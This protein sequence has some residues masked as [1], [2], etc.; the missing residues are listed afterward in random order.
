M[1]IVGGRV[2]GIETLE[3]RS[4]TAFG[5]TG[6]SGNRNYCD[7]PVQNYVVESPR[8]YAVYDLRY[9]L[10]RLLKPLYYGINLLDGCRTVVRSKHSNALVM[11]HRSKLFILTTGGGTFNRD[12]INRIDNCR[13][14]N[15]RC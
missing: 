12:H 10:K 8:K 13:I 15:E 5:E 4:G 9:P 6:E 11:C 7:Q 1:A 14:I 2:F 3:I